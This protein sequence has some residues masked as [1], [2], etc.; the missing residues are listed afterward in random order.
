[1]AAAF[2]QQVSGDRLDV[3]VL[4]ANDSTL[5]RRGWGFVE[6]AEDLLTLGR[7]R[8]RARLPP[9]PEG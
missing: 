4:M 9:V 5:A 3:V 2:L 8:P 7:V 6:D 1:M